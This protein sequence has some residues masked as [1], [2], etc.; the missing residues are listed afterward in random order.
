M[1]PIFKDEL[2]MTVHKNPRAKFKMVKV[3]ETFYVE[4][5]LS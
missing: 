3:I 2:K 1:H 4:L 5:T